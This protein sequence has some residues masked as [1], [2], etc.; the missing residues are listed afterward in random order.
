MKHK[1][2]VK[3]EIE[4]F[5]KM[6]VYTGSTNVMKEEIDDFLRMKF[7]T[8]LT[9]IK[10]KLSLFEK[11]YKSDFPHFETTV[12]SAE[13]ENFEHWDDYMEWKAFHYKYNE[14]HER[15]HRV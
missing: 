9:L 15:A 13:E 3:D 14:L 1:K 6:K 8:E 7:F 2:I 4:N 5:L 12:K 11:K 10:E